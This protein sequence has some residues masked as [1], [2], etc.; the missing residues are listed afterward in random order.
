MKLLLIFINL[1]FILVNLN[2]SDV[3]NNY[4]EAVTSKSK[5]NSFNEY[6]KEVTKNDDKRL[7]AYKGAAIALS[8]RYLKT[9]KEKGTV[10]KN[11]IEWVEFAIEKK[12]LDMEVR[13]VRLSVQQNSPK[14]LG[15]NKEIEGDKN[16][17][18]TNFNAIQSKEFKQYLKSYI[19]DSDKFTAEEKSRI[20]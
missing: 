15:Y 1:F 14:F 20:E 5:A 11:G 3:R 7:V 2:I 19:L 6:L 9:A 10:F 16:Y 13:F 4:K 17:L 18:L 8:A 12:P